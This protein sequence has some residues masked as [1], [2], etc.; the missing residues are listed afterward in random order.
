[1]LLS[2][3]TSSLKHSGGQGY[4]KHLAVKQIRPWSN[5]TIYI[6]NHILF[7]FQHFTKSR[8]NSVFSI[9][10]WISGVPEEAWQPGDEDCILHQSKHLRQV[11]LSLHKEW[12]KLRGFGNPA[13]AFSLFYYT[14]NKMKKHHLLFLLTD[15]IDLKLKT[16]F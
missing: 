13:L 16:W 4:T 1:M 3:L 15:L 12:S 8:E 9:G 11:S 10:P 2:I 5:P 14:S 6:A 7:T